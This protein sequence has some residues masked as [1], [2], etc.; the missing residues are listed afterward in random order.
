MTFK[1]YRSLAPATLN[2]QEDKN[3]NLLHMQMGIV[4]EIGEMVDV[5]KATM[6]YGREFD[7][8]HFIEEMGDAIWYLSNKM[9]MLELTDI[10]EPTLEYMHEIFTYDETVLTSEKDKLHFS[11]SMLTKIMFANFIPF[12]EEPA[13][14]NGEFVMA[15]LFF[16]CHINDIDFNEVLDTNIA[17]LK[18]RYGEKFDAYK[19][20]NRD[21]AHER[22][23]LE[24]KNEKPV[25]TMTP[26]KD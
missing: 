3:D 11:F 18:A 26:N 7:K 14:E 8:V 19:A 6:F 17:K 16:V 15:A 9:N 2:V 12:P 25:I 4:S 22:V 24:Q 10:K 21:L 13:F 5:M 20:N 23:V 1:E